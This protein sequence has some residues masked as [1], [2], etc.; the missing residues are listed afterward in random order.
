VGLGV[1]R[2]V[3]P[4]VV[5]RLGRRKVIGGLNLHL[6]QCDMVLEGYWIFGDHV[7]H[8]GLQRRDVRARYLPSQLISGI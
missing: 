2:Y 6:G 1:R 8:T 5:W 3:W 7:A 4:K